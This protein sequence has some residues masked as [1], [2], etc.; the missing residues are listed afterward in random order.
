MKRPSILALLILT[1]SI[2]LMIGCDNGS[3]SGPAAEKS[4]GLVK[5]CLTVDGDSGMAQKSISVSSDINWASLTFQYNAVPQ[6]SGTNIQGATS[7]TALPA[8]YS[9]N[10]S[11]GYFTPGQWVFGIRLL[12][13]G[14]VIYEGFSDVTSIS[15][16]SVSVAVTVHKLIRDVNA[17][18]VRISVTAPTMQGENLSVSFGGDASGG[19]Y[20]ANKSSL[21]GIT[22]FE[23]TVPDLGAGSYS[24][25]LSHPAS[26]SGAAVTI[27]LRE[28]EMAV[29]SGHL[30]NGI[31]QVGYITV[32]IHSISLNKNEYGSVYKNTD[33]AAVNDKVSFTAEP[34]SGS[35]VQSLN[36]SYVEN[37]ITKYVDYTTNG[38]LY[39]F[40][41]PDFDV[42]INVV[43]KATDSDVQPAFFKSIV[44]GIYDTSDAL[45]FG[46][47]D[48]PPEVDYFAVK[49]VRI[50]FD[51]SA[52][53]ICWYSPNGNIVKFKSGSLAGLFKDFETLTSINLKG[54][55]TSE[56]TDMS[57]LFENCYDLK[58]VDFNGVNTRNVRNMS[59]MFY[60]AGLHYFPD[61]DTGVGREDQTHNH[62]DNSEN[63][64]ISNMNFTTN[65]VENM[66][67]M[68]S[69]C[70]V[71]DLSTTNMSSWNVEKVED[72]SYMFAGES[73]SKPSYKYW[74]NK[75]SG[76]SI[77]SWNTISSTT[78]KNMFALCNRFTEINISGWKFDNVVYVDRM[79]ERCECL[80][81]VATQ[82]H[83]EDNIKVVFPSV[84][85]LTKLEDM[86][87]WFGKDVEFRRENMK[88]IVE[89]WDFTGNPNA[90]TLFAN[91]A[92]NDTS[93][94]TIPS[95]RIFASENCSNT[96]ANYR[97]NFKTQTSATTL[98]GRTLYFGG[99]G[100][101]GQRIRSIE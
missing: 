17:G 86:L 56:I 71:V 81:R 88:A 53:K 41:M 42:T 75:I 93:P 22:T 39:S 62:R 85:K 80:G 25:T 69:V 54:L 24:F 23:Y 35:I 2:V 50:W 64:V 36:I 94:E 97:Q 96:S 47:S 48:T 74:Y 57:S 68:F 26:G 100:I 30:D 49:D 101:R 10:M 5:V 77:S 31:W 13:G 99:N 70:A 27:D 83:A 63:I 15:N 60:H 52:K 82:G 40:Y 29:I 73:V 58:S 67:Y 9:D 89:S 87:Y 43:F 66:S 44:K 3:V 76:F 1:L 4:S 32:N 98:D 72:F 21:N 14:T 16:T 84:T 95:N 28:G 11:L 33:Y 90:D 18:A 59:K 20:T 6:W 55:D 7:W 78:F 38:N 51:T 91:N 19:P 79:F 45:S 8:V 46:R 65:K 61:Y 12:N 92:N 37:E 34:F